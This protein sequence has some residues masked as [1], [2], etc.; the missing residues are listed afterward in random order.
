MPRR[1]RLSSC[2]RCSKYRARL[3]KQPHSPGGYFVDRSD[4]LHMSLG[5][6]R[7]PFGRLQNLTHRPADVGLNC[8]LELLRRWKLRIDII[9]AR[10]HILKQQLN[11]RTV[12]NALEFR[13]K[14]CPHRATAFVSEHHE[15]LRLEV[16]A[17]VLEARPDFGGNNVTRHT[18]DE[19]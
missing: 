15:E 1:Q 7:S 3:W 13:G 8:A 12:L 18:N 5:H 17:R 6:S 10:Q 11:A 9:K 19:Q 2:R 4:K 14:R 16:Y